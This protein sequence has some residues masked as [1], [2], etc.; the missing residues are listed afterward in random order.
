MRNSCLNAE[1]LE[2]YLYWRRQWRANG[3]TQAIAIHCRHGLTRALELTAR[4][5]VPVSPAVSAA[6]LIPE[7]DSTPMIQ[8]AAA[9]VNDLLAHEYPVTE[10]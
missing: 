1:G 2:R 4:V 6:G 5:P 10:I 3:D 9:M 8:E 7:I